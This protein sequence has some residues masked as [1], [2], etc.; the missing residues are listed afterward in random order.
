MKPEPPKQHE[1]RA[2]YD[3]DCESYYSLEVMAELAGVNTQAVLHYHELGIISP[4]TD[5]LEFDTEGL[6]QLRRIEHLRLAHQLNDDCLMFISDLL[7][8]VERLRQQLRQ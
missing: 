3:P 1:S 7:H 5:A 2:V 6:R 4:G 8:E